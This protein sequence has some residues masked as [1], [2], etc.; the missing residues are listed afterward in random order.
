MA[1]RVFP[2]LSYVT[3]ALIQTR[4]CN[5]VELRIQYTISKIVSQLLLPILLPN[6]EFSTFDKVFSS[7]ALSSAWRR[8]RLRLLNLGTSSYKFPQCYY[9]PVLFKI[10]LNLNFNL[11]G[12]SNRARFFKIWTSQHIYNCFGIVNVVR[13]Q[14]MLSPLINDNILALFTLLM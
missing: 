11:N 12:T 6:S 2:E 7:S 8:C 3:N 10:N 4:A 13:L 1:I 9:P 5:A 14:Q